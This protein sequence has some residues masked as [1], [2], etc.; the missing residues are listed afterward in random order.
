M[1]SSVPTPVGQDDAV[2]D[3]RQ[4]PTA[5]SLFIIINDGWVE[6]HTIEGT[7]RYTKDRWVFSP[8]LHPHLR[9]PV[10][11]P[12]MVARLYAEVSASGVLVELLRSV[13]L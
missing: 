2:G 13:T 12:E 9:L 5:P 7:Y 10:V 8:V 6:A 1:I 3:T 4:S 11:D